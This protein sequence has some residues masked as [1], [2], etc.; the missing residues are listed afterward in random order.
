M[1]E[2]FSK[3]PPGTVLVQYE[4]GSAIVKGDGSPEERDALL[5]LLHEGGGRRRDGRGNRRRTW[6]LLL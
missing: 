3:Q 4:D 2:R 1:E 6:S 5:E